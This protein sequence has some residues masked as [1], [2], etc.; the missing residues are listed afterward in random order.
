MLPDEDIFGELP[1]PAE[2]EAIYVPLAV[3]EKR[4]FSGF[5]LVDRGGAV[6]SLLNTYEDVTLASAGFNALIEAWAGA[7]ETVELRGDVRRLVEA[8]TVAEARAAMR[9][10]QSH[11]LDEV[12]L[13]R[14]GTQYRTLL[15]ELQ[16][17]FLVMVPV[18]YRAGAD[19]LFKVEFSSAY[20]WTG[21]GLGGSLRTVASSLGLFEKRLAF[22]RLDIGTA[23]STHFEFVAPEDVR[24]LQG[25]IEPHRPGARRMVEPSQPRVDLHVAVADS[26]NPIASR[27]DR[28]TVG[29]TL[30]PRMSGPFTAITVLGW[31]T[32]FVLAAVAWRVAE[33]DAQTASAVVLV[34]PALLAT[35]LVRQGEHAVTGRLL[36]GVRW[37]GLAIVGI[38]LGAAVLIGVGD[39]RESPHTPVTSWRCDGSTRRWAQPRRRSSPRYARRAAPCR[40]PCTTIQRRPA[41]RAFSRSWPASSS[42]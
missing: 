35:Y 32:C 20:K 9:S 8:R 21:A 37:L 22:T 33:L 30:A 2:D 36:A 3:A 28:A 41:L 17:G 7:K 42:S 5:S 16:R 31:L 4:T 34:L 18:K 12:P 26:A 24:I 27:A 29:I 38:S 6:V 11:G 19:Q 25:E 39:L 1:C 10:A 40:P 13:L 23:H 14:P 15:S